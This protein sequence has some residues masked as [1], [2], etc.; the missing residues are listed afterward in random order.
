MSN[1]K[2]KEMLDELKEM[3]KQGIWYTV[4]YAASYLGIDQKTL[5]RKMDLLNFDPPRLLKGLP[6]EYL[7]ASDV[8]RLRSMIGPP[9]DAE[10]EE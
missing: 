7:L 5:V 2:L 4:G 9:D 1:N 8:E 6:G 10:T 3:G